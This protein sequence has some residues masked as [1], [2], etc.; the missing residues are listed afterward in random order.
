VKIIFV[1]GTRPEAIKMAP[2]YLKMKQLPQFDIKLCVTA[3][4][5]Q[6]MDHVID[7]FGLVPDY[8][9][10]LMQKG[11]S[12]NQLS[13]R[14]FEKFD[15]VL[16]AEQPDLVLVHGDTTT[17]SVA[18]WG[19]FNK[20]IQIGHVEAGLRTY[21][22]L[23]PF[24][25]ELNR[26]ITGKLADLHFAPTNGA[27]DNLLSERVEDS[28]IAVT[29][30]TIID[31]L[32]YGLS[33]IDQG[34]CSP[35]LELVKEI[36]DPE[37]KLV[38]VTGH[39][40][41]NFG[42]GFL[43]ICKA[44]RELAERK[45]VQVIYPVHLNPN[46]QDP[47]FSILSGLSNVSLIS[48]VDYP[49]FIYLM[50]ASYLILTDSGGVQEEAP[51][52]G[53]PVILMRENTERPEA[54]ESGCIFLAGTSKDK[55]LSYSNRLLDDDELYSQMALVQNPYGDGKAAEKISSFILEKFK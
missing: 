50:R 20:G 42:S 32:F 44:I 25:E 6:M 28:S 11:Q 49:A 41:E 53:K 54:L 18:A 8:D 12:L 1:I 21:D 16:D 52:L 45:D 2:L 10:D 40:R 23:S 47:V 14:I 26:Q 17:S 51:S 29:G 27:R 34:F 4:H 55:I 37:K 19:T 33:R 22:K 35:D 3:Q 31:A 38:L 30:N 36:I 46:V 48:P 24:P 13:A 5:R 39:R 15:A 9:L 7:F 43:E